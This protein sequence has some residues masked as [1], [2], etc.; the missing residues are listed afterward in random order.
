MN[1]LGHNSAAYGEALHP[2]VETIL[3]D[4]HETV[5]RYAQWHIADY[6]TGT[7][8]MQLEQEGA[9]IRFLMR[10]YQRGKPLPDD[11]RYMA[12]CMNLSVRVWKRVK[13]GLIAVGKIIAKCGC[14][15]NARFERERQIRAATARKQAES[16]R[17]RWEKGRSEKTGLTE[18]S[19]KFAGSLD[20]TSR[21]LAANFDEKLNEINVPIITD[22]MLTINQQPIT[23][24]DITA[25]SS[26]VAARGMLDDI[27][28]LNGATV[29]MQT[30]I[31][32]WMNPVMPRH[33]EARTWLTSTVQLFGSDVVRD[34]FA[35]VEAK[36][37]SDDIV[38]SPIKLMTAI[39]QQK[40][41]ELKS[42]KSGNPVA[43]RPKNWHDE[44]DEIRAKL[45]AARARNG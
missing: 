25:T 22:H 15:T 4:E 44:Q 39:C 24:K 17:L 33:H 35:A 23:N 16:A 3:S 36:H 1:M 19:P 32:K 12:T 2:E 37:A 6:I 18:V 38:G 5:F 27:D 41:A 31:A 9:Y 14:L 43:T 26:P 21:K 40:A 34:A 45:K 10:L 42:A 11:D 8:G 29:L 20:E 13:E 28:G 7:L 30:K